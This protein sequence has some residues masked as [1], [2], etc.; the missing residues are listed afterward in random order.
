MQTS[1]GRAVEKHEGQISFERADIR[2]WNLR[3]DTVR[4]AITVRNESW[5]RSEPTA[6]AAI[7]SSD[8]ARPFVA[9]SPPPTNF[10]LS[11]QKD[12]I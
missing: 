6:G 5:E 10:L 11:T 9:P 4:I 3:P 2:F 1:R 12:W 7:S 8:A